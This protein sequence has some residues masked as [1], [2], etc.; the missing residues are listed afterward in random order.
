M[1]SELVPSLSSLHSA[2]DL[3]QGQVLV[4]QLCPNSL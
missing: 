4:A 3:G 1:A 2:Q